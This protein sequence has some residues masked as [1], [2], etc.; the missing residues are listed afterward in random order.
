MANKRKRTDPEWLAFWGE[1]G[2]RI[3][4][5]RRRIEEVEIRA[6][7]DP[8]PPDL[9][10]EE[11]ARRDIARARAYVAE[12]EARAAARKTQASDEPAV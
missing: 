5:V 1:S 3:D 6:G 8:D 4:D 7:R 9:P 2:R 10:E 12:A 11:R